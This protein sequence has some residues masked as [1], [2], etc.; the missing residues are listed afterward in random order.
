MRTRSWIGNDIVDLAEPGVAGKERDRRFMDRVFTPEERE[1]IL[2][3]AAPTLALWKAWTAKETAFKI[4]SKWRE[5]VIFAH[6]KFEV[7][8]EPPADAGRVVAPGSLAEWVSVRFEDLDIRV[9]WEMARDYIHCIGQLARREGSGLAVGVEVPRGPR[10]LLAGILHECQPLGGVLS[11]AEQASV[12]STAS[13]RARL[14][15]RRLMDRWDLQGAEILRLWRAWGWSPPVIAQ[16]GQPVA[17]FDV[18]L[19]HDGR[20]VAAALAGPVST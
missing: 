2:A 17:G 6:R 8:P 3:A 14:L 19:S 7:G 13:E 15:A 9:R 16:E 20:F 1:R 10:Q 18:S 11:C 5:G 12:H 4:A